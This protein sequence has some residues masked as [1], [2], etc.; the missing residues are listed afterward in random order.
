MRAYRRAVASG[1]QLRLV[2]PAPVVRGALTLNGLDRLVPVYLS[3]P[4]ADAI[5][6]LRCR[7]A[8]S[9]ETICLR[10]RTQIQTA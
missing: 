1:T 2:V 7:E 8:S 6:A 3:V 10:P 9:W 5:T 4:G